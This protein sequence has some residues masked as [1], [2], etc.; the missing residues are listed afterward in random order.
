DSHCQLSNCSAGTIDNTTTGTVRSNETTRRS[1]QARSADGGSSA[2]GPP[3]D[4][5][6]LAEAVRGTRAVYPAAST[7]AIRSAGS[8]PASIEADAC[9]VAKLT[10]A[11]TPSSLLS[12]F[13]TRAAHD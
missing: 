4:A 7:A 12:F 8:I 9:S 1:R 13:S 10:V 6:G 3:D 2:P 11:V 5:S